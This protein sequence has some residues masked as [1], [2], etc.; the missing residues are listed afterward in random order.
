MMW[1]Y[2]AMAVDKYL[3]FGIGVAQVALGVYLA[4]KAFIVTLKV[5]VDAEH[6]KHKA[7]F[8]VCCIVVILFAGAQTYRNFGLSDKIDRIVANTSRP[9]PTPVINVPPPIVNVPPQIPAKA[10]FQFTFWPVGS[11]ERMI[12]TVARPLENGVVTTAITAKNIGGAQAENGQL[13][14]QLCDGCKFAEEPEDTTMPIGDP[15]VRR[16]HFDR[17]H[18]GLISKERR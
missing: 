7:I 16:K 15:I 1:R 2:G 4:W 9:Q 8:G 6:P 11:D 10:K 13:W 5:P 12:D 3:D 18:M 17:L 14:I